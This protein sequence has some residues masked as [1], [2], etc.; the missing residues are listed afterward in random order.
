MAVYDRL[1]GD[2][3]F[4]PAQRPEWVRAWTHQV[5]PDTLVASLTDERGNPIVALPLE[6]VPA[7]RLRIARF[8]GGSHANGSFPA[9]AKDI[10]PVPAP[11]LAAL[12]QAIRAGRPDIDVLALERMTPAIA[13]M[14]NPLM[15][16]PHRA[17][18]NPALA[19]DL[20][21][22]FDA[23]LA[24]LSSKRIKRHRAQARKF[25]ALGGA[26]RQVART[27]AEVERFLQAFFAMKAERFRAMGIADVFGEPDVRAFFGQLFRDSLASGAFT[28]EALD[29]GGKLRAVTGH[30]RCGDRL[31]CQF[32]AIASDEL[33]PHSPGDFLSYENIKAACEAGFKVY[34]FNV[35]DEP[36][37]RT[38]CD[39]EERQFDVVLP[40]TA[41]GRLLSGWLGAKAG[42]KGWVKSNRVLWPLVRKLRRRML[43]TRL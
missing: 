12:V 28:L 19:V 16:L 15:D 40:L 33:A 29:V 18:P 26:G 3:V 27:E 11:A 22:G 17:S 8:V 37:K 5:N 43:G 4:A 38:W 41:G 34:D 20:K 14:R 6:V 39:I 30:S 21:D 10:A 32:G 25:A 24:R 13:G 2:T 9:T 7:G 1:A 35:G 31:I 36:Y 23:I 42:L